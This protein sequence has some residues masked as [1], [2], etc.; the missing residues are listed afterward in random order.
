MRASCHGRVSP[1]LLTCVLAHRKEQP[2]G[3]LA[4]LCCI[5]SVAEYQ[6]QFLALLCRFEPLSHLQQVQIFTAGLQNPL[7][8]NV[9][10]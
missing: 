9:E 7:R 3:E 2:L 10:L 1:T 4:Q 5:S 6:T 8:T